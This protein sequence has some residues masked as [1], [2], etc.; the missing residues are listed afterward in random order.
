MLP[1]S[2]SWYLDS[3][4]GLTTWTLF[5]LEPEDQGFAWSFNDD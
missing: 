5:G 2:F 4:L 1:Q 3:M